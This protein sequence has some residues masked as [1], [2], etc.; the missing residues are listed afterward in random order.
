MPS[1]FDYFWAPDEGVDVEDIRD[2]IPFVV[3]RAPNSDPNEVRRALASA[4]NCFLSETGVWR[5]E[6]IPC[7]ATTDEVRVGS[8][9][10]S[11]IL[12]VESITRTLDDTVVFSSSYQSTQPMY[13]NVRD[14]GSG[15]YVLDAPGAVAG[16]AYT[17][18][19]VLTVRLGSELCPRWVIERHGEA[20]ASKA[21]HDLIA[22]GQ[23]GVTAHINT[24]RAAVQSVIARKAMGGSSRSSGS[25]SAISSNVERI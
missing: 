7:A 10:C 13:G 17:A 4:V 11:R 20:I 6:A 24:Y 3:E 21:A 2:L 14:D 15:L 25:G 12:A 1:A 22:K 5:R 23:P 8:G 9:G 16:D 18:D 19:V